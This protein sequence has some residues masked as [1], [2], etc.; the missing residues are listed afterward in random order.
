MWNKS[1]KIISLVAA[2]TFLGAAFTMT[3]CGNKGNY[4]GDKLDY[5]ST[6]AEAKSNGGFVVEKGDYVYFI[7]GAEEHTANNE[8][9][10]VTKGALMRIKK[11]D[12]DNGNYA[13]VQTVVPMLLV[14]KNYE[15]GIYIYDDYVYYATPTTDKNMSG[16]VENSWIDFKRAPLDGSS[17]M[18]GQFFRISNNAANYRF[19]QVDGVVYCLYEDTNDAGEKM[20]KSY[21]VTTGKTSVLVKGAKSSFFFDKTD[22]EN[23][24]VYYTM[25]VTYD[26]DSDH[27]TTAG[28]DQLYCVNA[29]AIIEGEADKNNASYTVKGGKTYDF[30]EEYLNAKNKEAKKEKQDQPYDLKDYSTYPYVNLGTLVLDGIG[31][32]EEETQ[33]NSLNGEKPATPDGYNYTISSYQNGGVYFTRTEVTKTSSDG[34]NKKLYYLADADSQAAGWNSVKGNEVENFDVVALNTTNASAT[35][36]YTINNGAHEYFYLSN[37][38]LYKAGQPNA[39]GKVNEFA[40][41]YNLSSATL[42]TINGDYLYYYSAAANGNNVSRINCTGDKEAYNALLVE[43]EYEPLTVA[44]VDWNSS[45]YK[46]EFIGDTLLYS[47]AQSFGSVAYNYIYATKLAST[48]EIVKNNEA[49]DELNEFI[50]SYSNNSALQALMRYYFRT[51]ETKAYEAVKDLYSEYQVEEFDKFVAEVEAEKYRK[52]SSFIAPI[53]AMTAEDADAIEQSWANSLLTREVKAEKKSLPTWAIVLIVVGSVLVVAAAVVGALLIIK[54]IKAKK[55][56]QE[57]ADAIVNA[58][59]KKI[60]TTDDKSI[61]VYA[62]EEATEET[63]E[64]TA[65][66]AEETVEE[67][68]EEVPAEEATE[69]AVEVPVAEE[70]TEE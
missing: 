39:E 32:N 26:A 48:T 1:K 41:A 47:N 40:L 11:A 27:A 55:A 52:E 17:A 50:N 61:D 15:A 31:L 24:N 42:W 6:E 44:Y 8:F 30:D 12:L 43:E 63:A 7:N 22:A 46:P 59:K 2:A 58:H 28:Y 29:A 33:F 69:E 36:I 66:V 16:Q 10:K 20:L 14:A 51:G 60:D 21:N 35:A 5:V 70:K 54:N 49:Y 56:A 4:K 62:D 68:A 64:E 53:G 45:W 57:E 37:G 23:P 34:E 19:V 65:P 25:A 13:N 18:K 3:A 38:T 67:V 9:G